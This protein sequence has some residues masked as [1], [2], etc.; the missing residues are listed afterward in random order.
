MPKNS[1]TSFDIDVE[2]EAP[3]KVDLNKEAV[4]EIKEKPPLRKNP[5]K[6]K[7]HNAAKIDKEKPKKEDPP[8]EPNPPAAPPPEEKQ[9]LKSL[10]LHSNK[11]T[12]QKLPNTH[13]E[14]VV[15][16]PSKDD[17]NFLGVHIDP[18]A[19]TVVG[20]AAAVAAGTAA[21]TTGVATPAITAVKIGIVKAKAALGFSSKAA[22]VVGGTALAGA[23]LVALEKKFTD[24]ENDIQNTKKEVGDISEQLKKLD[25]LISK[26][27]SK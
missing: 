17:S 2:D 24:Y 3:A 26:A 18:V 25:D 14:S 7:V 6:P 10:E 9:P 16:H 20:A 27:K 22:A 23:A 15:A 11:H 21:V 8:K 13:H 19:A 4:P 12:S 5:P 1:E